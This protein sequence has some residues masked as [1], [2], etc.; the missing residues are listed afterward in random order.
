MQWWRHT[1][2]VIPR[3]GGESSTPRP[4]GSTTI[5]SEYWIARSSRAMAA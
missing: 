5:A 1:L 3:Q 4:I 2:G